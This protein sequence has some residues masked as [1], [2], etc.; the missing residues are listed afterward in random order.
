MIS[1]G[2]PKFSYDKDFCIVGVCISIS[3]F[4]NLPKSLGS[5]SEVSKIPLSEVI[6]GWVLDISIEGLAFGKGASF[7]FNL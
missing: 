1:C 6:G 7:S 5:S 2:V 3:V 4:E